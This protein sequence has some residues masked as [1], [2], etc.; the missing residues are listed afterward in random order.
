[1]VDRLPISSDFRFYKAITMRMLFIFYIAGMSLVVPKSL[2]AQNRPCS[3]DA[4]PSVLV[5]VVGLKNRAGNVRIRLFGGDPKTYFDKRYTLERIEFAVP[6]SGDVEQCIAVPRAGTYA[7]D[8]RHD[9]NGNGKSDRADGAGAS[10]NPEVSLLDVIFKKKPPVS[11]VQI[12]V[13]RGSTVA[14]IIVKYLSG[15]KLKPF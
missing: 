10:G 11:K 6:K 4:G 13:G 9:T 12:D 5:K 3:A 14:T 2:G 1:L 15:G 8:V 7:V